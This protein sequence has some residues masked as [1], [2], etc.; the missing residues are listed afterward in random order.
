LTDIGKTELNT[1][2]TKTNRNLNNHYHARK[3]LTYTTTKLNET[4]AQLRGLLSQG[5][6]RAYLQLSEVARGLPIRTTLAGCCLC[7]YAR[8][9]Y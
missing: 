7:K 9:L 6:E 1:T 3:L 4:I 8:E 2:S 5:K